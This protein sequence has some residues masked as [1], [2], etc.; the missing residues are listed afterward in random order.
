MTA[1]FDLP[2]VRRLDIYSTNPAISKYPSSERLIR[3]SE[4]LFIAQK[5]ALLLR[6]ESR[7]EFSLMSLS[8]DNRASLVHHSDPTETHRLVYQA[9]RAPAIAV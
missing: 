9:P 3:S 7:A 1:D 5:V 8:I 6:Q 4:I 2:H